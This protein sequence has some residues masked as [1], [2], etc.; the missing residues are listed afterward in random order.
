M[1]VTSW[2]EADKKMVNISIKDNGI[3]MDEK[4][5][6]H[7]FEPFFTTKKSQTG[8]ESG[9]N[10]G[11]GVS[12]VYEIIKSHDGSILVDSELGCGST[13]I[14]SLHQEPTR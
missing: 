8:S 10:V 4:T 2:L 14:I 11:L 5:R 12:V 3:G 6:S 1:P 9:M 7:M 13:I